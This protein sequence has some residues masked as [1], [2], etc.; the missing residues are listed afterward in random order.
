MVQGNGSKV[1]YM[2]FEA[3]GILSAVGGIRELL[4]EAGGTEK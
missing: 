2:P 3:T 1:V 4:K